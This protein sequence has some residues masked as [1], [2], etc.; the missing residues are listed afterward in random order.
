MS[1]AGEIR[2]RAPGSCNALLILAS[3]LS[4][5]FALIVLVAVQLRSAYG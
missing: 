5:L 1:L 3:F 2:V 4:I